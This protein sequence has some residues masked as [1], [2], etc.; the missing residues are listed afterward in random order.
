MAAY[1]PRLKVVGFT[2]HLIIPN[3]DLMVNLLP[4]AIISFIT[5]WAIFFSALIFYKEGDDKRTLLFFSSA[6]F[7]ILSIF[8]MLIPT[9]TIVSTP[10]YNVITTSGNT[11]STAQYPMINETTINPP[12][13]NP[14]ITLYTIFALF[15]TFIFIIFAIWSLRYRL[16]FQ[17]F[18]QYEREMRR[19]R[20]QRKP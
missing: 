6:V 17:T 8:T 14:V 13:S 9:Y 19:I 16:Q 3:T 4:L 7:A 18:Q 5:M 11:V 1:I 2:P 15:Q 10:A 20:T 12:Y